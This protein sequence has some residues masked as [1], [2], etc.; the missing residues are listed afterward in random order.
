MS[1][2]KYPRI[3]SCQ[4]ETIV[5]IIL[6]IFFASRAV[7]KKMGNGGIF[8]HVTRFDQSHASENI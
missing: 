5:F 2:N 7:F 8:G 4:M 3:F 6:Q 1:K